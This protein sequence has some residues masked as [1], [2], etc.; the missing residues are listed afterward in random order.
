MH[1]LDG[2]D[3]DVKIR[4]FHSSCKSRN[5]SD[6]FHDLLRAFVSICHTVEYAHSQGIIHCDIKPRNIR[7][8][9]FGE[10]T[11]LDWGS[12]VKVGEPKSNYQTEHYARPGLEKSRSEFQDDIYSLGVTLYEILTGQPGLVENDKDHDR[13]K[14]IKAICMKATGKLNVKYDSAGELA[15][16]VNRYLTDQEVSAYPDTVATSILRKIRHN[17]S[18]IV[19][20][21]LTI[22]IAALTAFASLILQQARISNLKSTLE[23]SRLALQSDAREYAIGL[24]RQLDGRLSALIEVANG[25]GREPGFILGEDLQPQWLDVKLCEYQSILP[26]VSWFVVDKKGNQR[27]R[28]PPMTLDSSTNFSGRDYF[29]AQGFNANEGSIASKGFSI[30][31]KRY[32]L[33]LPYV[34]AHTNSLM[35]AI[36]VPIRVDGE[37]LGLVCC[38]I[39]SNLVL[40][41]NAIV[42]EIRKSSDN[43]VSC[44]VLDHPSFQMKRQSKPVFVEDVASKN[45][46]GSSSQFTNKFLDPVDKKLYE[47]SVSTVNLPE[48]L[49]D[50][51]L[52]VVIRSRISD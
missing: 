50:S 17:K 9:R 51:V 26:S 1:F 23:L 30:F 14:T 41:N 22:V 19:I 36:S 32:H 18:L 46:L 39:D 48:D 5:Y 40:S 45:F 42:I 35:K 3:L 12:A 34:S 13:G 4:Q 28:Y 7:L 21:L 33:S 49:S 2:Y 11:L 16:D 27:M 38:T 43:K 25:L 10:C 44:Q 29:H 31:D 20:A 52:R 37:P 15:K 8:R 24:E 6:E 47:A